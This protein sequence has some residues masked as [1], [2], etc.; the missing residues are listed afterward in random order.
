[1]VS[2]A[3]HDLLIQLTFV[4]MME[5]PELNFYIFSMWRGLVVDYSTA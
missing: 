5:D 4:L 3:L 2:I 1:M